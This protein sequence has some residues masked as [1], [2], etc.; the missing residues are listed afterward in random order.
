[1]ML[2]DRPW[3]I[4]TDE[5]GTLE[6]PTKSIASVEFGTDKGDRVTTWQNSILLGRIELDAVELD[7]EFGPISID[8]SKVKS[9][10][11]ASGMVMMGGM[12]EF[13]EPVTEPKKEN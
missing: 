5:L 6:I 10:L 9:I 13:A 2:P 3:K 4:K 1:G 12:S 7:S 11:G 8:R